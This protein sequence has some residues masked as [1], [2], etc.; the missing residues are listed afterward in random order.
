MNYGC[1][2]LLRQLLWLIVLPLTFACPATAQ[3]PVDSLPSNIEIIKL[4]WDKEMRLP[5]NFDPSGSST[6]TINDPTRSSRGSAAGSATT[7][8]SSSTTQGMQPSAP[9]RLIYVY[10]YSMKIKNVGTREIEGVAWDYLFLNPS[11]GMEVGRHQFL[12]FVKVEPGKVGTFQIENR[13][14]PAPMVQAQTSD[15]KHE[16]LSERSIIKCVLYADGST[17]RDP[18][19]SKDICDL[20]RRGKSGLRANRPM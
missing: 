10:V 8:T 4:K 6:G 1:A 13:T 2:S 9:A 20:L 14:P 5:Q 15:N 7:D 16:K 12:S 18:N 11:S 19:T 17:W 3:G